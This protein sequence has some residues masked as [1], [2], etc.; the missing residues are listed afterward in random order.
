VIRNNR[1]AA[2]TPPYKFDGEGKSKNWIISGNT[3]ERSTEERIPGAL[4]VENLSINNR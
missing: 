1:I 4:R 2:D 3:F